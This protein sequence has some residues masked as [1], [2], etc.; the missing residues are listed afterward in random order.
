MWGETPSKCNNVEMFDSNYV[1]RPLVMYFSCSYTLVNSLGFDLEGNNREPH[2]DAIGK[3][4]NASIIVV[5][6]KKWFPNIKSSLR[7]SWCIIDFSIRFC[8]RS[9]RH[10]TTP[11]HWALLLF[12]SQSSRGHRC[13]FCD[14]EWHLSLGESWDL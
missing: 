9:S 14:Y 11:H 12:V 10:S 1:L 6:N 2:D 13:A 4:V 8:L 5:I 3:K 7:R